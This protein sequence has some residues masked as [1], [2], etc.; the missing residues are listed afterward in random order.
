LIQGTVTL[1]ISEGLFTFNSFFID[2]NIVGS[3]S[4]LAM[5][6]FQFILYWYNMIGKNATISCI[7]VFQ[8]ILY[9]YLPPHHKIHGLSRVLSIHSLLIHLEYHLNLDNC[10]LAF[11]F[12]L[13]WYFSSYLLTL[14]HRCLSIHSLLIHGPQRVEAESKWLSFNSFFIDTN[15]EKPWKVQKCVCAFNSFFIDTLYALLKHRA[16]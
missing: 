5:V 4:H 13:Y 9:W 12:I 1:L 7:I 15:G 3:W 6:Y 10:Y 11:Q 14:A 16:I 2:T 8:F